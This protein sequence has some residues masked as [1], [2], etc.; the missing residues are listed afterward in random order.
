MK[1][2][3]FWDIHRKR[4]KRSPTLGNDHGIFVAQM[5][6]RR[7]TIFFPTTPHFECVCI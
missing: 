3:I 4:Q 2:T 1:W 7:T 6:P 5:E